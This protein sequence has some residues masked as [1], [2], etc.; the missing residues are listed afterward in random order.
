MQQESGASPLPEGQ[1]APEPFCLGTTQ[2]NILRI[3]TGT[4]RR[5]FIADLRGHFRVTSNLVTF[6]EL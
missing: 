1:D 6:S 3:S 2:T 5:T 4:V